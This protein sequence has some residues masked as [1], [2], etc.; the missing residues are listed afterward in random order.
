MRDPEA[1]V[2]EPTDPGFDGTRID[3]DALPP[4]PE[5]ISPEELTFLLTHLIGRL[6]QIDRRCVALLEKVEKTKRDCQCHARRSR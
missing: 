6:D 2:V 1:V 4:L 5:K 3:P